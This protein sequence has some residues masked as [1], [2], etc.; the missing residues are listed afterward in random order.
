MPRGFHAD[1][2][3]TSLQEHFRLYLEC[4][5]EE[6]IAQLIH[7]ERPLHRLRRII[8]PRMYRAQAEVA[9][10]RKRYEAELRALLQEKW[11]DCGMWD[12]LGHHGTFELG[13]QQENDRQLMQLYGSFVCGVAGRVFPRLCQPLGKTG[14]R[15]PKICYVSPHLTASHGAKWALGWAA[16]HKGFDVY[17]VN[18]A[19]KE[20]WVTDQWRKASMYGHFTQDTW[21]VAEF[22]RRE[23]FDVVIFPAIGMDPAA[24][25]IAA[26]RIAPIQCTAWGHP[27][28]SGQPTVDYYLSSE[29]MEPPDG[30]QWYTERLVRLPGSGLN[31]PSTERPTWT[32]SREDLGLPDGLLLLVAQNPM[33]LLPRWDQLYKR[34]QERVGGTVCFLSASDENKAQ[35]EILRERMEAIGLDFRILPRYGRLDYLHALALSDVV[36]DSPG[37]NGGNTT[38]EA[39]WCETP[40]VTLAGNSMRGRHGACFL[41]QAGYPVAHSEDEYIAQV[42]GHVSDKTIASASGVFDDRGTVEALDEFLRSALSAL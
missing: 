25:Q 4:Q 33:K 7:P 2:G 35:N 39:L 20:D 31:I 17:S 36:L 11:D 6:A 34:V 9:H 13:Y 26:F 23:K 21:K 19:E 30:Q 10:W 12:A 42:A 15:K 5:T 16:C 40:V 1:T 32:R 41:A 38:T 28:T 24:T 3:D 8:V 29:L 22:L 27:I 37:W 14:N 18:M